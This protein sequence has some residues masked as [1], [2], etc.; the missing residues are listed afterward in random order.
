[1]EKQ[2][3]KGKHLGESIADDTNTTIN[4]VLADVLAN[5]KGESTGG[6]ENVDGEREDYCDKEDVASGKKDDETNDE[7]EKPSSEEKILG[8]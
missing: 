6:E 3:Y 4:G 7:K 5:V 1:M 8:R 2:S